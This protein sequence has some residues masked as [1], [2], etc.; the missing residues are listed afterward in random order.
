[1]KRSIVYTG[2]FSVM[3]SVSAMTDQALAGG[4]LSDAITTSVVPTITWIEM[5]T[6]PDVSAAVD[7]SSTASVPT[8]S[9]TTPSGSGSTA[10]SGEGGTN[11]SVETTAPE[12]APE[13]MKQDSERMRGQAEQTQQAP[14]KSPD[15]MMQETKRVRKVGSPRF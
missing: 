5:P 15:D 2:M 9:T 13:S 1:M 4:N 12:K 6:V 8:P 3:V 10:P 7:L 14:E 11:P